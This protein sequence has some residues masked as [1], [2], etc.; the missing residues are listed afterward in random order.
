ML[1]VLLS[2]S[3][4]KL[5]ASNLSKKEER[6]LVK[7]LKEKFTVYNADLQR[8]PRV[9]RGLMSAEHCFYNEEN[10]L[11]PTGLVPHLKLFLKQS[12]TPVQYVDY[13][14]FPSVSEHV[15]S[16]LE[17]GNLVLGKV[18]AHPYQ[19][20]ALRSVLKYRCGVVE[21]ATGAGKTLLIAGVCA[22]YNTAHVLVLFNRTSLLFQTYDSL[23]TDYGFKTTEVGTVG[24]GTYNDES[25]VTLMTVQSYQ[26]VMHLF[27][28]VRVIVTDEAHE[29]GRSPTAEK[30]IYSCQS[31]PVRVGMS[32]TVSTI[33]NP[34]ERTKLYGNVGPVIYKLPYDVLRDNNY[35]ANVTVTM[36][37]IGSPGSVKVTGVWQDSYE[38]LQVSEE[39]VS[40]YL[41][42]GYEL[43]P[44]PKGTFVRKLS[45]LGDESL[46]YTYNSER[47][48][49]I[50]TVCNS[51]ERVLV[52]YG[53]LAHG[54]ELRKLLPNALLIS[55]KDGEFLRNKA[56]QYLQNEKNSVV[57]ASSIFD[58]GVDLPS[59]KT[60]VLAGSSVSTVRVLQKVGRSTRKDNYTLKSDA[61]V[62]DFMQYDNAL[63]LKQSKKRKKIYE[64]L[65]KVKVVE[66]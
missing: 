20:E 45:Q 24:G 14:V 53:K 5:D 52:L 7:L 60:L 19:V 47:N 42:K 32:A 40:V 63:S 57:L 27:P 17:S 66:V 1:R 6:E 4:S 39:E 8:D 2:N 3:H 43:V 23:T 11:L 29:T 48:K 65:L 54:E 15:V 10:Q 25:R 21:A 46:L 31:A 30:V 38:T 13:R 26:N 64:D 37:K 9:L 34:Y 12:N 51:R 35:L 41:S 44:S 59:V 50:A 33:E 18:K 62:V 55:G 28:K 56:K 22:L 58:V 49:L 16:Q 61:E 36:Y